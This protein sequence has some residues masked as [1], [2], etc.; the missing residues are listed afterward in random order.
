MSRIANSAGYPVFVEYIQSTGTQ[1]I[2]N[3]LSNGSISNLEE[4]R[5]DFT[6]TSFETSE[7]T[8]MNYYGI[9]VYETES[10]DGHRMRLWQTNSSAKYLGV[11][12][13]NQRC[14]IYVKRQKGGSV[15][16]S[17]DDGS[18][19]TLGNTPSSVSNNVNLFSWSIADN[20]S[21]IKLY[22]AKFWRDGVLVRDLRPCLSGEEGH[23]DKPA[24]YDM[25]NKKYYYNSGI[26][27]FL[28]GNR[29]PEIIEDQEDWD[30][31]LAT[32]G[33]KLIYVVSDECDGHRAESIGWAQD[34]E[35]SNVDRLYMV[36]LEDTAGFLLPILRN[37]GITT[38]PSLLWY[39]DGNL[40]WIRNGALIEIQNSL[41]DGGEDRI[42][43]DVMVYDKVDDQ[44]K[45]LLGEGVN[46]RIMPERYV[47]NGDVY[48][49][50]HS[51]KSHAVCPT[52]ATSYGVSSDYAAAYNNYRINI[53]D[54]DGGIAPNAGSFN[55]SYNNGNSSGSGSV[56][57]AAGDTIQS[58]A[59]QITVATYFGAVLTADG[60]A[61]GIYIG[62]HS[63]NTFSISAPVNCTLEELSKYAI[64]DVGRTVRSGD[65]YDPNS[66][67]II[68]SSKKNWRSTAVSGILNTYLSSKGLTTLKSN[69]SACYDLLGYNRQNRCSI[70]VAGV[71]SWDG[72]TSSFLA[73]GSGG[74]VN[75]GI[76]IMT[77]TVFNNNVNSSAIEGSDAW[78]MY[79]Y[80]TSLRAATTDVE[81]YSHIV[82]RFGL[83]HSSNLY[84]WY[85]ACHAVNQS[86]GSGVISLYSNV[87]AYETHIMGR[88]FTVTYNYQYYPAYPPE[89]NTLRYEEQTSIYQE[90]LQHDS[91]RYKV[92]SGVLAG[93]IQIYGT[94]EPY[95]L[96]MMYA[97]SYMQRI[98]RRQ[99]D[100]WLNVPSG[101]HINLADN[102]STG[103][104]ARWTSNRSWYFNGSNR[105]LTDAI[106][107]YSN[108]R[109]RPSV[110]Y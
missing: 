22:S 5:L 69:S 59:D 24:L 102:I 49:G 107:Y 4:A 106:K 44:M 47:T 56:S 82:K 15:Q 108:F 25:V 46:Y 6:Y 18:L 61:V 77:R 31:M 38:M 85:L 36:V 84:N 29:I 23:L 68:N 67:N 42:G 43:E 95:D 88:V 57:W 26:G 87:S 94:A 39:E 66:P 14:N 62:G 96:A 80:Y 34:F 51:G 54:G 50:E 83:S 103:S 8:A 21:K 9:Q 89:Y 58:I 97:D 109:P 90:I 86:L 17:M 71:R 11:I 72:D 100:P 45:T 92:A 75:G 1:V 91:S 60:K 3:V 32:P 16:G 78:K 79:N 93:D 41:S 110:A 99:I 28:V 63:S 37:A 13:L 76:G 70:N 98:N 30:D 40:G 74:S 48:I 7:P 19:V 104:L 64:F 81:L 65:T 10:S 55:Y 105:V 27:T 35:G 20:R 101:S 12:T 2:L 52:Y 33:K 73:D 53:D